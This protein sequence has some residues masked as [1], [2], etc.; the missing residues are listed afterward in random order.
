MIEQLSN[1]TMGQYHSES[2]DRYSNVVMEA[3]DG[4]K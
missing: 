1:G 3:M 4:E 2:I